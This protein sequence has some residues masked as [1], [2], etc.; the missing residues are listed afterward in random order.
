MNGMENPKRN[1]KKNLKR[2]N[3]MYEIIA[4]LVGIGI[5]AGIGHLYTR[6]KFMKLLYHREQIKEEIKEIKN[7]IEKTA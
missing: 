6:H 7:E 4:M 3:R 2:R 5:G 1:L